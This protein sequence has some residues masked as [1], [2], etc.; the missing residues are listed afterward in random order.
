MK[1]HPAQALI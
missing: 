1:L